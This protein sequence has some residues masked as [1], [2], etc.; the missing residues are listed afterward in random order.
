MIVSGFVTSPEDQSRICLLDRPIRIESKSLM[1][2]ASTCFH[3][4]LELSLKSVQVILDLGVRK[5]DLEGFL[6]LGDR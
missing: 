3:L 2:T 4:G 5:V 1:S 6:A